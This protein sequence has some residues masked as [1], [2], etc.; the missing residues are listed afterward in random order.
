MI[1]D[2]DGRFVPSITLSERIKKRRL[3]SSVFLSRLSTILLSCLLCL[4]LLPW[5]KIF[6]A[7]GLSSKLTLICAFAAD[8][9]TSLHCSKK[10]KN[11]YFVNGRHHQLLLL[12]LHLLLLLCVA[13]TSIQ[14]DEELQAK[15]VPRVPIHHCSE[16]LC[17]KDIY[18]NMCSR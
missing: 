2:K 1:E 18:V 12:P 15:Q 11:S 4:S 8:A 16:F 6:I 14:T 13:L 10:S 5:S 7:T 17:S 3:G 9:H